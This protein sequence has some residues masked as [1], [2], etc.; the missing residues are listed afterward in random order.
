MVC[1]RVWISAFRPSPLGLVA[2]CRNEPERAA[3]MILMLWEKVEQL[4]AQG[5]QIAAL[6]AKLG[7]DSHNS[8]KPPSSDRHNPG[9]SPPPKSAGKKGRKKKSGAQPGHKGTTLRKSKEPDH[10]VD[11]P[12]PARCSCGETQ[13][14]VFDL[15]VEIKVEVTEYRAPVCQCSSCGK[16]IPPPSRPRSKHQCNMGNA[17]AP[18]PPTCTSTTCCPTRGSQGSSAASW[19]L[20]LFLGSSE[21]PRRA[22]GPST[23]KYERKSSLQT[24]C[25]TMNGAE[26]HSQT[27]GLPEGWP[28]GRPA[29]RSE[30][31]RSHVLATRRQH[32]A[33]SLL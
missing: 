12:P 21:T 31:P 26:R 14:Q 5:E 29:N 6:S 18:L 22:P 23:R 8:S 13:R 24:S 15:P 30:D 19:P 27:R 9:G 20:A 32:A 33:V 16:K 28:R 1:S 3:D 11:L 17:S 2:M 25:T 7:K 10:V 4:A